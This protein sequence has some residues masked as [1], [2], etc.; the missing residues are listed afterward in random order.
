MLW[1]DMMAIP[2]DAPHPGNAL[3]FIDYVLRPEIAP[4]SATRSP[5]P[6]PISRRRRWSMPS[7]ATI[8]TIYPPASVRARLFFDKPATPRFRTRAHP[9]L[10]PGQDG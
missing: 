1:I 7:C 2:K 5:T 6:I 8:P 10:D 9:R 4:R 3:K